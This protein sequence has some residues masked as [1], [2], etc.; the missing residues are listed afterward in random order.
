MVAELGSFGHP[1]NGPVNRSWLKRLDNGI[2]GRSAKVETFI[3]I[4]N[5]SDLAEKSKQW[6]FQTDGGAA[7]AF[8]LA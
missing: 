1:I 7:G 3:W 6:V 4:P 2:N 8:F 5:E